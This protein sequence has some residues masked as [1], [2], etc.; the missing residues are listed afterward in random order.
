VSSQQLSGNITIIDIGIGAGNVPV[1]VLDFLVA[2]GAVCRLYDLDLP[3]TG[4]SYHGLDVVDGWLQMTREVI[5]AYCDV[6]NRRAAHF[7]D[8]PLHRII[9]QFRTNCSLVNLDLNRQIPTIPDSQKVIVFACNVLSELNNEGRSNLMH[10]LSQLPHE[11][12]AVIIEPGDQRRAPQLNRWRRAFLASQYGKEW[13]ILAPCGSEFGRQL[14]QACDNCWNLRRDN[15]HETQLFRSLREEAHRIRPDR[16]AWDEY[17]N[18]LLSQS[19]TILVKS[20]LP[21]PPEVPQLR[22]DQEGYVSGT[23]RYIGSMDDGALKLCPAAIPNREYQGRGLLLRP[24]PATALPNLQ[25]GDIIRISRAQRSNRENGQEIVLELP[26]DERSTIDNLTP[27]VTTRPPNGFLLHYTEET[28]RA[29]DERA[30]RFFGFERMY[31]FQH[32]VLSRVLCGRSICAIAATGGGKSECFILPA[33][34]LAG[35]T[36]V[37]SPLKSLMQDQYEQR[38]RD[39][40]GF[41]DIATFINGDLSFEERQRRLMRMEKGYYKIVYFTP[42]QLERDY[43]LS[44]LRRAQENVGIRYITLDEAHCISQWGH[45]FRP[46]YLNIVHRLQNAGIDPLPVR[47]ALTAT[48]SP[49]VREEVCR[50]LHLSSQSIDSGGDLYVHSSNRP[51]LNFVVRICEN[52]VQKVDDM[53]RRLRLL[54]END[55]AIVF[56]PLTGLNPDDVDWDRDA[57]ERWKKSPRVTYF[58]SYLERE[59]QERVSLYHGKMDMD[60]DEN[61]DI[62]ENPDDLPFGN[63]KGRRRRSEQEN[64]IFGRRRIMVATK[65]FG[66]GIDKPNVRLILHRTPPANLE[67]YIQE[68]GR[69][70]RDGQ[71]AT[72]VLYFSP[73]KPNPNGERSDEEIQRFFISEKYIRREDVE[74]MQQF[75]RSDQ[76]RVNDTLYFTNDEVIK[77]FDDLENLNKYRWPGFPEPEIDNRLPSNHQQILE[78]GHI[79]SEKTKYIRRIL[80]TMYSFRPQGRGLLDYCQEVGIQIYNPQVRDPLSIIRSNRYFGEVFRQN[81]L[82]PDELRQLIENAQQENGIIPLAQRLGKTLYE[83]QA[84]LQDI[85]TVGRV[86]NQN[87]P[88]E[89]GGIFAPKYG[90]ARGKNN[91]RDWLEYAGATRRASEETARRRAMDRP[92]TQELFR[93]LCQL[94]EGPYSPAAQQWIQ[95]I[96]DAMMERI[97]GNIKGM[98]TNREISRSF[99]VANRIIFIKDEDFNREE[100]N[101]IELM[102]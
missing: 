50:E 84:M 30:Y 94:C 53:V 81:G 101:N 59:L 4:I 47:I 24:S 80:S 14:P 46:S 90:P 26:E 43:V 96:D 99:E 39:R 28:R 74:A 85:R 41:G 29:I 42:E 77:F 98:R 10:L 69:A 71:F 6:L 52:T 35:L 22:R 17:E 23:A 95:A 68:A 16:R 3:V 82:N 19:Y 36:I 56:L 65:G 5:D 38:L 15:F 83:V 8:A 1:A 25:F 51:E 45:D 97:G 88:L 91:L 93:S 73:D 66:M 67:A 31:D 79:Y 100:L 27:P 7:H 58:A 18:N 76:R 70:G 49:K 62:E 87:P 60:D 32:D 11:S 44:S 64:F 72:V 34:L 40:Y 55:A 89:F 12:C 20:A 78:R 13:S 86:R 102:F 57:G 92:N 61:P 54:G 48:A 63:L 9:E 75:L 2:W 37:V 33:L 21:M